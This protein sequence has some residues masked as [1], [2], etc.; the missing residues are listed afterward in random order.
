MAPAE[1][2]TSLEAFAVILSPDLSNSTPIALFFESNSI[3]TTWAFINTC[4]FPLS[5]AGFRNAFAV[6][7][8]APLR[9]VVGTGII[10]V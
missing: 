10:P 8:R 9:V 1:R 7:Q 6:L 2:M 5:K 3:L 4:R